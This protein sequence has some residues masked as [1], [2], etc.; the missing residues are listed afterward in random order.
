[1][2]LEPGLQKLRKMR[3]TG[4][5]PGSKT[6][7]VFALLCLI[8][9][10]QLSAAHEDQG[11]GISRKIGEQVDGELKT[12]ME[13]V[14]TGGGKLDGEMGDAYITRSSSRKIEA[15]FVDD[16]SSL[17]TNRRS[18]VI[19]SPSSIALDLKILFF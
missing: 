13:N 10:A 12:R 11:L 17:Q 18:Q 5:R 19:H 7:F 4:R 8:S 14:E 9:C 3:E 1:M 16:Q 15:H 2:I 6:N